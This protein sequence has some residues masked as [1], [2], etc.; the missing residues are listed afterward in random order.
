MKRSCPRCG[1]THEYGVVCPNTPK[2]APKE[3]TREVLFRRSSAWRKKSLLI[4]QRD[5]NLCRI[6][7]DER[8]LT[9]DKLEVHHITPLRE[10]F[11]RRFDDENLITLCKECHEKAENNEVP[12]IRL[13]ELAKSRPRL[14]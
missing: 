14:K 13:F 10:D 8:R 2:F 6:C 11:S 3:E 1:R 7:L 9:I 4:R 12:R 5:L